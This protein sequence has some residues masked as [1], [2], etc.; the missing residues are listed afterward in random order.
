MK[1]EETALPKHPEIEAAFEAMNAF[2]GND[3]NQFFKGSL[4]QAK[5][6]ANNMTA[7]DPGLVG[8][9]LI[10]PA[11]V[12]LGADFSGKL[13]GSAALAYADAYGALGK[14]PNFKA[15]Q[16]K[17]YALLLLASMT[18][19]INQILE[20]NN[21]AGDPGYSDSFRAAQDNHNKRDLLPEVRS[22]KKYAAR[23]ITA[24]EAS[25]PKLVKAFSDL[26]AQAETALSTPW[27]KPQQPKTTANTL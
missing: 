17:P 25:E 24:L 9:A 11:Q 13:E 2:Y 8:A 1:F 20:R 12:L 7:L 23:A 4:G 6:L 3:Q 18:H 10:S 5:F 19:D 14:M 21:E 27:V 16:N 26:V 15:P 22:Y